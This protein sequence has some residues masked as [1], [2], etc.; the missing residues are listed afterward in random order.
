M[1]LRNGKSVAFKSTKVSK[2]VNKPVIKHSHIKE[3]VN[4]PVNK[5][6]INKRVNDKHKKNMDN[7]S[8]KMTLRSHKATIDDPKAIPKVVS[9][10]VPDLKSQSNAK[11]PDRKWIMSTIDNY[12]NLIANQRLRNNT[13]SE[14]MKYS[15]DYNYRYNAMNTAYENE[16]RLWNE[17][18][19]KITQYLVPESFTESMQIFNNIVKELIDLY[20]KNNEYIDQIIVYYDEP[21]YKNAK[22]DM[23]KTFNY[24]NSI[25]KH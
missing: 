12:L 9:K 2:F 14:R 23:Q 13:L 8:F 7:G 19:H 16:W 5:R 18:N 25:A 22:L 17:L 10:V 6:V 15:S 21:F 24:L 11:N 4:K 3:Y 1:Q 20:T